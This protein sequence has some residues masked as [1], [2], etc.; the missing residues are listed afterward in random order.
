LTI[1][2]DPMVQHADQRI[3]TMTNR[4]PASNTKPFLPSPS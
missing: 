2:C 4:T 3:K 1:N